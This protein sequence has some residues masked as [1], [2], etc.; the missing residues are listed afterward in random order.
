MSTYGISLSVSL[1]F[2][3]YWTYPVSEQDNPAHSLDLSLLLC[4][5]E[6][7]HLNRSF[8]TVLTQVVT[9]NCYYKG[10]IEGYVE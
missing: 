10:V 9:R 7:V 4:L 2:Q 3:I 6:I 5:Y 1:L 8:T